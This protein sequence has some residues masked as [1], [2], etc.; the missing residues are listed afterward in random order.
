MLVRFFV[1]LMLSVGRCTGDQTFETKTVSVGENV[2]LTCPR[3]S[4]DTASKLY[5]IRLMSG[6]LPEFLGGT[7]SFNYT[8][9]NE[10][11]RIT[12]KQE[13]GTFILKIS[14]TELSDTGLYYCM[15]VKHLHMEIMKAI[16]LKI[17]GPEPDVTAV[18]Q[19]P[20][21]DPVRPEDSVTLQC[22]VLSDP[23]SKSC[24]TD[25]SVYWF[26]AGSDES[27]PSLIYS[28]GNSNYQCEKSPEPLSSQSCVY[29][30][31]KTVSSSDVGTYYCAV[32]TCG[33]ILFGNGTKLDTESLS[34]WD[35]QTTST[36]LLLLC[37]ILAISLIIIAFLIYAIKKKTCDSRNAALT[38]Q[39][40][41]AT[42]G[43]NQKS[44]Q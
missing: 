11:T 40:Y 10:T 37:T 19:D 7:F 24:P 30:F 22:S 23:D 43:G 27:H 16:F 38:L 20:I 9:G 13:P 41:A 29:H 31:S 8:D 35:V 17:K 25:H 21:S 12:A 6:N 44:Q 42:F 39:T 4:S 15:K 18:I 3:Q 2:K 34:M 26:R 5:W 1:L 32:A 33:Q 28:H 36:V 14:K